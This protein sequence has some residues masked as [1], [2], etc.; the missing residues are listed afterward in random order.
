MKIRKEQIGKNHYL[1]DVSP[2]FR[3]NP[4]PPSSWYMMS[5]LL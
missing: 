2:I 1:E 4:L 3:R 5:F